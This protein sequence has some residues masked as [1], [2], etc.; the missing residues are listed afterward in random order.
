MTQPEWS[1][2]AVPRQRAELVDAYLAA[3][4]RLSGLADR[5]A[6]VGQSVDGAVRY[7]VDSAD[8]L[9]DADLLWV[10][11][12]MAQLVMD[13]ATD[14]PDFTPAS[15]PS[16]N[17]LVLF[18]TPLPPLATP[19]LHLQG[20]V[21]WRGSIPVWGV[22]WHPSITDPTR[23]TIDILTRRSD[24]PG[25]MV[26]EGEL[27]PC[28]ELTVDARQGVAFE[29]VDHVTFQDTGE[30]MSKEVLGVLSML[31]ALSHLGDM[32]TLARR[33]ALDARTGKAP[34][35]GRTRPGDLIT[36]VDLRPMR[37]E[38]VTRDPASGRVYHSRWRVRG[39]W[40]RQPYGPGQSLRKTIYRE[41]Y[42]KGPAGAPLLV[43]DTVMVWRR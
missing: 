13:A 30:P 27:Q 39:H 2:R 28:F 36:M 12:D 9:R 15:L 40:A 25:G 33:E 14:T 43:S 7:H 20:G 22:G 10:T 31:S 26:G 37:E 41:P 6:R 23:L 32:P 19:P 3:A 38:H 8:L 5:A 11:R 24:L 35:P 17:M 29:D 34:R 4:T 42:I 1:A 16:D 18:G 21:A